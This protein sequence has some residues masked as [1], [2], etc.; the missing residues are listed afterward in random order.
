MIYGGLR[1]QQ[2]GIES[3]KA[4]DIFIRTVKANVKEQKEQ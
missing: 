1:T 4:N 3:N 2:I